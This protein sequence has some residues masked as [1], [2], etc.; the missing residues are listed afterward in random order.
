MD[1]DL[2][3]AGDLVLNTALYA[4]FYRVGVWGIPLAISLANIAG[5]VLL[6]AASDGASAGSTCA[7]PCAR[8]SASRS[9]PS[10]L[11]GGRLRRLVGLDD[12]LG[13]SLPAQIV[14]LGRR[15][16]PAAPPTSRLPR[17]PGARDRDAT[18][19]ARPLTRDG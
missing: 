16:P 17:A 6:F 4:V 7:R 2:H 19:A 14:S 10:L 8:S 15:S 18:L 1:A 5:V 13:R 9:R 11:A 3:R 12:A